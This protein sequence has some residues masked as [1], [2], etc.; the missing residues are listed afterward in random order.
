MLC[1]QVLTVVISKGKNVFDLE[2][3][4]PYYAVVENEWSC[5]SLKYYESVLHCL[6]KHSDN[7][8]FTISAELFWKSVR[9]LATVTSFYG[10]RLVNIPAGSNRYIL[11]V[12]FRM[13]IRRNYNYFT[14]QQQK[15]IITTDIAWLHS[16][17]SEF[18]YKANLSAFLNLSLP[19]PMHLVFDVWNQSHGFDSKE[20]ICE[21]WITSW[22]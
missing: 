10:Q 22:R 15:V 5:T 11:S 18:P 16:G 2:C 19:N 17:K 13:D 7:L 4:T 8:S 3:I 12:L 9:Y 14:M 1:V 6:M 21:F 20:I